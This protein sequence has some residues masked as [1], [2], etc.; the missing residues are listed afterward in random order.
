[1]IKSKFSFELLT[2]IFVILAIIVGIYFPE[3]AIVTS[4]IGKLFIS[5]LKLL[6]IP[7]V[8]TSIF[9]AISNL[10]QKEI[11]NLG[12]KTL[13]YYLATSAFAC[14]TGLLVSQVFMASPSNAISEIANYKNQLDSLKFSDIIMSFMPN[15]IFASI[16]KGNIIHLVVFAFFTSVATTQVDSKV[17]ARL[18]ELVESIHSVLIILIQYGMK[19]APIGI[20]SLVANIIATTELSKFELVIPLFGSI[21]V[22][23]FIHTCVT[24]PLIAYFVGR[25]NP[26][27]FIL[28]IKKPI[29]IALTT[30]SSTATLPVSMETLE[31]TGAVKA[32]TSK[33]ILPLGATL[34]MDGS[35]LY[36][37]MVV[38]FL[39]QF[40][41]I[42]LALADQ[43]LVFLFIM[44]SS[45]GTAGIPGGGIMMMGA[46][47][48]MIGIPL[49]YLSIYL[50]VDRIWDYPITAVNVYG[51]LIGAKTVDR[52]VK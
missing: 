3:I 24:L 6:I 9:L 47:M 12:G 32:K 23:V 14:V 40:G 45:A 30:A 46:V 42:H 20:A 35:A 49:E 17:K 22:A 41:G 2:F 11:L 10:V 43:V 26:W 38:L 33:F 7:L 29:I 48:G 5:F 4:F 44:V 51:D 18:T 31:K 39:A 27:K 21:G 16:A 19:L 25:F 1:V 8:F 15:N 36:Q 28:S 37:A 13:V 52:Y 50:L 34:N